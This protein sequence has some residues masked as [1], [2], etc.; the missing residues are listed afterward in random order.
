MRVATF[1]VHHCEGRDGVIDV[2]RVAEVI[3]HCGASVVALQELD[4]E[5]ARS[6]RVDQPQILQELTGMTVRFFPTLR[7]GQGLFGVG[8][9][10]TAPIEAHLQ[11]LPRAADEEP[12]AVIVARWQGVSLLATHLSSHP[13]PRPSQTRALALTAGKSPAPVIVM[14][15]LNQRACSLRP[16]LDL[17]FSF[18]AKPEPTF[19]RG[20]RRRQIDFVLAGPGLQVTRWSAIPSSASDHLALVA[21]VEPA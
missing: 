15:D 18:P 20:L 1:N 10:T 14:G 5:M 7:R 16:L 19:G 2:P 4:Q 21:E 12:R 13:G 9:A 8:L 6:G 11:E 3:R 17:G